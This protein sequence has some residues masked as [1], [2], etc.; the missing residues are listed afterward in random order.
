LTTPLWVC[1][2]I[3]IKT[4]SSETLKYKFLMNIYLD[5][6]PVHLSIKFLT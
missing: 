2:G 1:H 5:V 6:T 3:T 4:R